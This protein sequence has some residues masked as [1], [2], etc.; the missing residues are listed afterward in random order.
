MECSYRFRLYPAKEQEERIVRNFGCRRFVFN[1]F[2]AQRKERYEKTGESPTRFEQDKELTELK[3]ELPWLKEADSTSLQSALQDLDA[4]YKHFFRR[5]RQGKKPGYP[6]FKS[7][8]GSRQS[9]KSKC[10]GTNIKVLDKAIQLPKLGEVKCRVSRKPEG[11]IL[12]ATV[13]RD[14]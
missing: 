2:L 8:R 7:R 13:S 9:Y 1:H 3:K 10:V 12:S 11:R 14:P 4:A 6:K 5:A